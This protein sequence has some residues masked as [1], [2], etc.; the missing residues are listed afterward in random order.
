MRGFVKGFL[1]KIA[2][3]SSDEEKP[4]TSPEG[5]RAEPFFCVADHSIQ[6]AAMDAAPPILPVPDCP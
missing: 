6:I 1:K 4:R 5:E 2:I 3:F